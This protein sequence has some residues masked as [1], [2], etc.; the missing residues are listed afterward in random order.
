MNHA[1]SHRLLP[2]TLLL[3]LPALL[4]PTLV[5]AAAEQEASSEAAAPMEGPWT[6]AKAAKPYQGT[7]VKFMRHPGFG[8]TWMREMIAPFE[9]I[10]GI[11][12]EMEV[13]GTLESHRKRLVTWGAGNHPWDIHD[14]PDF[15]FIEYVKPGWLLELNQFFDNPNLYQPDFDWEDFSEFAVK[16]NSYEG[17]LY[18]LPGRT[19]TDLYYYRTDLFDDAGLQAPVSWSDQIAALQ[20]LHQP[21]A[22]QYGAGSAFTLDLA[23]DNFIS[24]L[25]RNGGTYLNSANTEAA[26]N[27]PEG[28]EALDHMKQ[29]LE[30]SAP[31]ALNYGWG[32]PANL[33][34]EGK[35]ATMRNL[36][37]FPSV[38][39][40][41][42]SSSVVGKMGYARVPAARE[43]KHWVSTWANALDAETKVPEAAWL[44]IQFLYNK[45]NLANFVE[46]TP[47]RHP[48]RPGE[49]AERP[50][51]AREVPPLRPGRR[52]HQDRLDAPADR[53]APDG[54]GGGR[55]G[56]PGSA[57]RTQVVGAG[58]GRRR[59]GGQREAGGV[60]LAVDRPPRAF[61]P[62]ARRYREPVDCGRLPG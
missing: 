57:A 4:W 40:N 8:E 15:W 18:T 41:P 58:A 1:I 26:F 46:F 60:P 2:A 34:A 36:I 38:L 62:R 48:A 42:D 16:V 44:F 6:L 35:A 51:A 25:H 20:K 27:S 50:G 10:T 11:K 12:V 30:Y 43:S 33:M 9:E 21:D 52:R 56:G 14:V 3:L 31:G 24:L 13:I 39:E 32:E 53:G 45:E 23:A 54:V 55:Q 17:K 49:P 5:F 29:V 22:E 37:F 28:I 47:R 19:N 7:T 59:D 61:R